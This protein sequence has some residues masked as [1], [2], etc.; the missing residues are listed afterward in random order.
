M[1]VTIT[2]EPTLARALESRYDVEKL[3]NALD[4]A[5]NDTGKG[6][7]GKETG[8][9]VVSEESGIKSA[10][11]T[12]KKDLFQSTDGFTFKREGKVSDPRR[13]IAWNTNWTKFL[14][15][16]GNP[17][18]EVTVDVLPANLVLWLEAKFLN[19]EAQAKVDA[20][21]VD[22]TKPN[23]GTTPAKNGK[24]EVPA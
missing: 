15:T 4:S 14:K 6:K 23:R 7:D 8:L 1:K 11:V 24:S 20:N 21:K 19:K 5:Y 17:S 13:F 22:L 9:V 10:K 16:N 12:D 3:Q 2:I 18:G